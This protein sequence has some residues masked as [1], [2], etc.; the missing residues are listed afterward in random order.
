MK[1]NGMAYGVTPL[2][3]ERHRDRLGVRPSELETVTAIRGMRATG[4]SLRNIAEELNRRGTATKQGGRWYAS[5]V[6][7]L[8]QNPLYQSTQAA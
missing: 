6:R 5:T 1:T 8:L 7:Y 4:L 2:G 3:F